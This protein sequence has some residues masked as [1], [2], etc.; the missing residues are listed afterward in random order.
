[1]ARQKS[2]RLELVTLCSY[3]QGVYH[4]R[5]NLMDSETSPINDNSKKQI[6]RNVVTHPATTLTLK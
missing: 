4:N 6:Q 5:K 3:N 2:C 1:M